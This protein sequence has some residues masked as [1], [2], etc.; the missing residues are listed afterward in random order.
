[1]EIKQ[2]RSQDGTGT[3]SYFV[4]DRATSVGILIDPN[5]E[6]LAALRGII[7]SSGVRLT[8]IIDTH[9]HAD[10]VSAGGE[11]REAYGAKVVMHENTKNKWRIVDQGDKFGIGDILRANA[12][13]PVDQ[14]VEDGDTIRSGGL[15]VT[16]LFTPGHTD[17]HL[18]LV[19]DGNIFTG[20]LLLIGQAGR[21]D[22]PGGSPEEQYESLF[23]KILL[24]PDTFRMY[25]GHDYAGNEYSLLG[26]EKRSNPFLQ[27]R[28][29]EEYVEFVRDFFPPIAE[30]VGE[31]GKMTLQ[32]GTTR[33][34]QKEED[35]PTVTP[36]ELAS[37]QK[38]GLVILDVREPSELAVIGFIEGVV[39]IPVGQLANRLQELPAPKNAPII[40]VCQSGARSLEA[41][42]FLRSRGFTN[43]KN[44]AGGT[45]GWIRSGRPVVRKGRV[46]GV[47]AV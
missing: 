28:S 39:N 38:E 40:C 1:M 41:T 14:Y 21:S 20:D 44:L 2:I 13:V 12:A 43:V 45:A 26:D 31:G 33:V 7:D 36:A 6:D 9:T 18:S 3:L 42:H 8:H 47:Q 25:P 17:N 23:G 16:M 32:C 29:K 37:M 27:K 34:L 46:S 11:L 4:T 15:T 35:I 22:L 5:R 24:L 30:S 19:A 10:H